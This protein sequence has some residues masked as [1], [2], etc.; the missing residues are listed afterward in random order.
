[1]RTVMGR[2]QTT[3]EILRNRT[4]KSSSMVETQASQL[5][6]QLQEAE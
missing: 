3:G 1:M 4:A 5:D 2:I 6:R